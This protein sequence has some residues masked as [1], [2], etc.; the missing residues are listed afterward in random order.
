MR[1]TWDTCYQP[2]TLDAAL[3]LLA[4]LGAEARI[5]AGGTDVLVELSR[6]IKPTSTLIDISRIAELRGIRQVGDTIELGAL[7]THN[8]VIASRPCVEEAFP[9]A[10]ACH[11]IGAPQ[12][13]TRAT[14]AGNLVTASP[15]NDTISP[16]IALDASL[17][18][19][20]QGGSRTVP[21]GEFFTGFRSTALRP[22]ELI[23]S[24]RIPRMGADQRGLFFKLGLRQAQAIS[25]IHGAMV[26]TFD[27]DVVRDARIAL[28]CL[29]PTVVRA[30]TVEHVLR[31]RR[32]DPVTCADAARLAHY[33]ASP[34]DDIRGSATYRLQSLER[35]IAH[36]LA[37]LGQSRERDG[38]PEHV[39]L[40]DT[41]DNRPRLSREPGQA[42]PVETIRT[43]LNG[44]PAA[45]SGNAPRKT[46][47]D[48][49]REDAG[50]TGAK[51][52]CAEGEC[53][54]CTIWLN[55]Q[56]VMSCLVPAAQADGAHVTTIEGLAN[57]EDTALHPLQQAFIDTGA[58]QCGF[59]IPGMIM[60]GAKLLEERCEPT[61]ADALTA[62][63]GNIC[64]C[65]GYRKILDAIA[66][67]ST[68][69][70]TVDQGAAS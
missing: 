28:G 3:T 14:V 59:C 40:L 46:L 23:T 68:E 32:L 15:A 62:V 67:A 56:A 4:D 2:A 7:T 11:E 41:G 47:L 29:A 20:S 5:V 50:L 17:V 39:I 64:R 57:G 21:I 69:Q 18:L 54:A 38:W 25:V 63:S 37:R 26:L 42:T 58:V 55:G 8:D 49:V 16:L 61:T 30:G 1:L 10:Q 43:T 70:P 12:L 65:T 27:G 48:L 6:D 52:G 44:R 45:F 51:E 34:I 53:G 31:G 60:A 22:D 13:R 35:L 36:S 24:I 66:R 19:T 9:L 33:D